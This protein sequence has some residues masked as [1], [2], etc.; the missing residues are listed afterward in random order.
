MKHK[1]SPKDGKKKGAPR[2]GLSLI[3]GALGGFIAGRSV[4][5]P[6]R[7]PHLEVWQ[8]MM[9]E[10]RGELGAAMLGARVQARYDEHFA[11][12]PRFRSRALRFHFESNILPTLALYQVL[13]E[14]EDG[15]SPEEVLAEVARL[16][17]VAMRDR[18]LRRS[19]L[20]AHIPRPFAAFRLSARWFMRLLFPSSGWDMEVVED[21]DHCFAFNVRRCFYL[22]VLSTY[23][24][25]E[26]TKLFCGL[27]DLAYEALPP[28]I[29]WQRTKTLGRGDDCCDFRWCRTAPE[30]G[31]EKA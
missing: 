15:T 31:E 24:P 21:N 26:L 1:T 28:A 18:L 8:G 19:Q 6:R 12:R 16:L 25:P 30:R 5:A 7:M 3:A 20:F 29:R 2:F 14:D 17:E 11:Q 10:Q 23:G 13:Q 4:S 22:D 27:D 9:A